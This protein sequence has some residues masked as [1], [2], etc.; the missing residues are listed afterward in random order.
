MVELGKELR[1]ARSQLGN[2]G[3]RELAW[4]RGRQQDSL[5]TC[6]LGSST[7]HAASELPNGENRLRT[8]NEQ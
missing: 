2:D 6:K 7:K 3:V 1:L 8:M 5:R 4:C